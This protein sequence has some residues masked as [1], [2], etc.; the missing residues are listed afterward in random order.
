MSLYKLF[1]YLHKDDSN[2]KELQ[3]HK[4]FNLIFEKNI[5]L[6][7]LRIILNKLSEK[8]INVLDKFN[9][10]IFHLAIKYLNVNIIK[11]LVN[12]TKINV[13]QRDILGYTI[14]HYLI[15][16]N[17]E[18]Y[19]FILFDSKKFTNFKINIYILD[20]E[21]KSYLY[22][23]LMNG[24]FILAGML[25]NID[26]GIWY[27]LNDKIEEICVTLAEV[28]Q[29]HIKE[30][31]RVE[32]LYYLNYNINS[33]SILLETIAKLNNR[34]FLRMFKPNAICKAKDIHN[35]NLLY[36]SILHNSNNIIEMIEK[37]S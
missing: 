37:F 25:V 33:T 13:N 29:N 28:N 1:N 19:I 36:Y 34:S 24:M 20:F 7:E 9:R 27:T 14:V 21:D 2:L 35:K 6:R 23:C 32:F 12:Y 18:E 10:N 17:A 16:L 4:L 5:N 11:I 30:I 26:S 22:H 3:T 15:A 31:N 8:D